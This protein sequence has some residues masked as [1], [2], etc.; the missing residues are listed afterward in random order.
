M[1]VLMAL[2][3]LIFLFSIRY[4]YNKE[5]LAMIEKGAD[6]QPRKNSSFTIYK[7]SCLL[8]GIGIGMFL[9]FLLSELAFP[10]L[11]DEPIYFSIVPICAGISLIISQ[12]LT[13]KQ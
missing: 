10:N 6:Y 7:I 5:K 8:I 9:S 1:I 4:L 13:L 3:L 2:A 11:S 12:K